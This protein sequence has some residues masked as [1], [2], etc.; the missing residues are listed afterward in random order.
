MAQQMAAGAGIAVGEGTS[1]GRRFVAT[2]LICAAIAGAAVAG[3]LTASTRIERVASN[4]RTA[5]ILTPIGLVSAN[6]LMHERMFRAMNGLF[7]N[8]RPEGTTVIATPNGVIAPAD[9]TRGMKRFLR[10]GYPEAQTT[11][12]VSPSLFEGHTLG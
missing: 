3:R 9:L 8:G 5:V 6:E 4:G 12:P 1:K 10:N 11:G 2:A 7:S